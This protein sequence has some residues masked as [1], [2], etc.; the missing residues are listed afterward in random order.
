MR[1]VRALAIYLI[2]VFVGGGLLAP[3]LYWAATGTGV[4]DGNPAP[5]HRFVN[6]SLLLVALCGLWPLA[7]YCRLDSWR[8]V[9][10]KRERGWFKETGKGFLLGLASLGVVAVAAVLSGSRVLTF[11][12]EFSKIAAALGTAAGTAVI[13]SVLE[14]LLFRGVVFG[15]LRQVYHWSIALLA[16][17]A[18]YSVVHFFQ[19]TALTGDVTWSSGLTMLPRMMAGF[20]DPF[21]VVP[22]LL[23]LLLAGGVLAALYQRRGTLFF[24]IGAHAG[25]IFWLKSYGVFTRSGPAPDY[26]LWGTSKLIDGWM[27]AVVLLLTLACVVCWR[28]VPHETGAATATLGNI[29][30]ARRVHRREGVVR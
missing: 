7:Y 18:L 16:S 20:I 19:K 10:L 12:A 14:E 6:R 5:F 8:A 1:P 22:G 23:V 28:A 3:W 21:F 25:W 11:D 27:A 15:A 13:V 4:L 9:G 2:A 29:E 30:A 17:S 24:S 26:A